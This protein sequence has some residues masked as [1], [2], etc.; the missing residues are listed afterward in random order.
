MPDTRSTQNATPRRL[1]VLAQKVAGAKASERAALGDRDSAV[2]AAVRAGARLD[3]IGH[4]AGIT[5]AAASVIARKLLDPRPGRG[6]PYR[7]RRGAE[8]ALADVKDAARRVHDAARHRRQAVAERDVAVLEAVEA[9]LSVRS[10]SV[11]VAMEPKVVHNLVRRRRI[12]ATHKQTGAVASQLENDCEL[13][14]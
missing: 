9:G 12:E 6:G 5:K 10:I 3:E 8:A 13:S 7:R 4:A 1:A 14:P 2:V 11:E